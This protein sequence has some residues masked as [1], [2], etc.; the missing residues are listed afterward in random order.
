M[1]PPACSGRPASS[2]PRTPPPTAKPWR[3]SSSPHW[4][5]HLTGQRLV[6]IADEG[7]HYVPFAALPDPRHPGRLLVER[8]ELIH[9]PS[10]TALMA[11]LQRTAERPAPKGELAVLADPVFDIDDPRLPGQALARAAHPMA[12]PP[13]E[14]REI[15]LKVAQSKLTQAAQHAGLLADDA[16]E[17][18]ALTIPRLP[19]TRREADAI[20]ALVPKSRRLSMTD[21]AANRENLLTGD[22]APVPPPPHCLPRPGGQR[23]P[24]TVQP[25][26]VTV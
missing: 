14:T 7:L 1:R 23:A 10:A 20:L 6:V 24:G 9:I 4:P 15:G 16:D 11:Q 12:G 8:H 22:L 21:F 26:G 3:G 25:P 2:P 18:A 13:A 5:I 19:G 17:D